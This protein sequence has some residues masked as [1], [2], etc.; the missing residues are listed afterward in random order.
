MPAEPL[1]DYFELLRQMTGMS[2][3][4]QGASAPPMGVMDPAEIE[5][6]IRELQTVSSWL[7][8]Q[9][10]ALTLSIKALEYQRDTLNLMGQQKN[11]F[12]NVTA[13]DMARFAAA[14]DPTQWMKN[15]MPATQSADGSEQNVVG[16]KTAA[17]KRK[18]KT[19]RP[20]SR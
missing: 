1:P 4:G 2:G 10:N 12:G 15:V 18:I 16:G 20:R 8:M 17:N 11:E 19:S 6:R 5:K 9:V 3:L 14:F 7:Q 13:D